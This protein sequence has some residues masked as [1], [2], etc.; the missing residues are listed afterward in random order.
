MRIRFLKR[1]GGVKTEKSQIKR[2]GEKG[3]EPLTSGFGDHCSTIETIPQPYP[4]KKEQFSP[5]FLQINI[6][7][8]R[9][10]IFF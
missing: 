9:K 8:K 10:K 3:F 6:K 1:R 7:F 2:S 4:S 5:C